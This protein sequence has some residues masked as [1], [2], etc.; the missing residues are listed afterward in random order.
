MSGTGGQQGG[1]VGEVQTEWLR[2]KGADRHMR[3][4]SDFTFIEQSGKKWVAKKG[5]LIDGASIPKILWRWGPPFVGDYRRASV[6]HDA[7]T[8]WNGRTEPWRD[9]HRMFYYGC[10][11]DGVS[12]L[13]A[14]L[15]FAA[16]YIFGP[17]W[18]NPLIGGLEFHNEALN[19]QG[20]IMTQTLNKGELQTYME[21]ADFNELEE[22]VLTNNP[23]LQEI[24]KRAETN[25]KLLYRAR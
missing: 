20:A 15:M 17:K 1:F 16:V 7:Y 23:D 9:T 8:N 11:A 14:K 24:E 13:K 10:R 22:W 21:D 12:Y 5:T 18:E 3:L 4:L 2:H 19:T 25:M 6:V